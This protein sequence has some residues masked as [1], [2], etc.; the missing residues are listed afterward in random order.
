MEQ[1]DQ[2]NAGQRANSLSFRPDRFYN[3]MLLDS[4][5]NTQSLQFGSIYPYRGSDGPLL[6]GII[7]DIW[8]DVMNRSAGGCHM[9]PQ[10][11]RP[12]WAGLIC[13]AVQAAG[14]AITA[15]CHCLALGPARY[16]ALLLDR[17]ETWYLVVVV[18]LSRDDT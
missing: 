18:S 15:H 7:C 10:S 6:H 8:S 5:N 4:T 16:L 3:L 12:D 9:C 1:T 17:P 2:R 11:H 14:H 13:G